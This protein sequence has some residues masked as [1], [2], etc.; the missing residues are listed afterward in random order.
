ME[1]LPSLTVLD[2]FSDDD[3]IRAYPSFSKYREEWD[4]KGGPDGAGVPSE[5]VFEFYAEKT[6]VDDGLHMWFTYH[7][8]P[9]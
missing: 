8:L 7:N 6:E 5:V 1:N 9:T 2:L 3:F 4:L